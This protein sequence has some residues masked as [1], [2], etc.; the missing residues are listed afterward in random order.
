[1]S[2]GRGLHRREQWPRWCTHPGEQANNCPRVV[3]NTEHQ[4]WEC[5]NN[6]QTTPSIIQSVRPMDPAFIDGRT[7]EY[8][9]ASGAIIVV[10][11]RAGRGL[12]LDSIMPTDG[13]WVH[14]FTPESKRSS[15]QWRHA[16]SPKPKKA[17]TTF[18]AGK[19]MATIFWDSKGVLYMDF[20]TQRRTIN[21]QYFISFNLF[22]IP[23]ILYRCG[24]S[25]V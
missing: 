7:Q 5:G 24:N 8:T 9:T 10:A 22:Y 12:F 19:V 20:L 3:W 18:S 17:K 14:Y 21:V 2:A 13:T 4:W 1:M 11:V 25:H 6:P 16:G 23:L 15:M